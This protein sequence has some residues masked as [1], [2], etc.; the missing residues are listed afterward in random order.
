MTLNKKKKKHRT[1]EIKQ[2]FVFMKLNY[3]K[4]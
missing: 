4:Y 1:T 3:K 2:K